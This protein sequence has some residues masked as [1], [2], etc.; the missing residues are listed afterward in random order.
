MWLFL[1]R[2]NE[3]EAIVIG[4]GIVGQTVMVFLGKLSGEVVVGIT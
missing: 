1:R 2:F 4:R 3:V